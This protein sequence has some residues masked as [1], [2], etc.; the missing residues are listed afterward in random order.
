MTDMKRYIPGYGPC[1][2]PDLLILGEAPSYAEL[3]AGRPFVG[4]AGKQLD[5]LLRDA[6]IDRS[7]CWL[8]NVSKYFVPFPEDRKKKI[9]F[10]VRCKQA[11]I[12]LQ[13]QVEELQVEI[14]SVNPNCILVLGGTALEA[15]TKYKSITDY[16]GSI[17]HGMGRKLV[18]SYHPAHLIHSEGSEILG[19]W[20]R[21][22]ML[23]D[24]MRAKKQSSFPELKL[25]YRNLSVCKSSWQLAEFI[26]QG[27]MR[28][29]GRYK[30]AL[31]IEAQECIPICLGLAFDEKNGICVPL[32]NTR[33]ISNIPTAD[34]VSIWI[35]LANLIFD[36]SIDIIGQNFKYDQDKITRLGLRIHKLASDT[37]LKAF[38]INPELPKNLAFNTSIYTEEPFY[39]NEGMYEGALHDLFI[40]CA[41]DACVTW[42]VDTKMDPDLD[43]LGMRP[44]YEN[45]LMKLH[46]LYLDIENE[47][48]R[49]DENRREELLRKY[50]AMDEE[51]NFELFEIAGKIINV[52]S[53]Q[54]V[55]DFLYTYLNLPYKTT[56]GEEELTVLLNSSHVKTETQKRAIDIILTKRRVLK[57]INTY[58]LAYPDYDGRMKSTYFLCLKTGRTS[59]GQQEPP[60]RPKH[61]KLTGEETDKKTK[62]KYLGTAFQTMTKHGDIGQDVRSM[63]IADEGEIFIQADSSQAEAR[64]VALLA[65]DDKM[66]KAYDEH[67]I[68]ALTASWF[69]GGTEESWSKKTL[70]YEHPNRFIGKTLRH[71]GH[72]GAKKRRAATEVN[73]MARKYKINIKISESEADR[74]L[75]IFHAMSP[76]IQKVFHAE[77]IRCVEKQRILTAPLPFGIDAPH[78]GKRIFYERHGDELFREAFSY[79]PQRA[80]S[81]NTKAAALRIKGKHPWIRIILESHDALLCSVPIEKRFVAGAIIKQEMERAIDFSA[82]SLP[83][84]SLSIPCELETGYN[85]QELKKFKIE[86]AV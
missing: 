13:Q 57:T 72:L 74:Y 40:G 18:P 46:D 22:V 51:L 28:A 80:V 86:V 47:G 76:N 4:P 83:R 2:K 19:Y 68:H 48:F 23:F 12:D 44:F 55:Q 37:M 35:L 34:M 45:F 25:P 29:K 24:F 49:I 79:I 38:A 5:Y 21:Q 81:D 32:W 39:K 10:H 11:G 67:D 8:T 58:I 85:Y 16:R 71:A 62:V 54:Q 17:L 6:Q 41:R 66:L 70:G 69:M 65:N 73:T 3:E 59:T 75:K 56:T 14:N 33:N 36:S 1:T 9:P 31:D 77:I 78:G 50:I 43:E 53:W 27:K 60:I 84:R 7:Q 64:V 30:L 52:N 20:V 63:Y 61:D 42:E 82:C 26:S 15:V